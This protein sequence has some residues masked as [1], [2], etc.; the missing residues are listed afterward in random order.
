[1]KTPVD[2]E[3]FA[4][5][6]E[7]YVPF[8]W[9]TNED[10][11]Q[12]DI[13]GKHSVLIN[14]IRYWHI[15][16][17]V[18][19]NFQKDRLRSILDIGPYP[20]S[21][22]KILK[23]FVGED[24]EYI[25]IGLG[26][27]DDYASEMAKLGGKLF[28]TELDPEFVEPKTVRDWPFSNVD[29]CLFL[30]AIEHLVNPI[31]CLEKI[32]KSLRLGGKLIIT[33]D[34]ITSLGYILGMLKSGASPNIAAARSH[35]FYRGE[36]RPHFREY[37]REELQFFLDHCGFRLVKHEYFERKQGDY[38]LDQHGSIYCKNRY[39]GIKGTIRRLLLRYLPHVRD[40]HIL[41]AEK[42]VEFRE[43]SRSRPAPTHD[44]KEWL[45]MR[46]SLGY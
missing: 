29:C 12:E 1:M 15:V 3:S 26:F 36:W 42:V 7:A 41:I 19:S 22:I 24:L 23:T 6:V 9:D 34:N 39:R 16:R 45:K 46:Q 35:L 5:F 17:Y 10:N 37:S 40:H 11:H 4:R 8:A 13:R 18:Q 20:G 32:N 43:K 30:D 38:Y 21:M 2:I 27:S 14:F 25:G 44:M 33:T 28:A 31:D